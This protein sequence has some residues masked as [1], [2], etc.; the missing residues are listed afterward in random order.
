MKKEQT[1]MKWK[2][3]LKKVFYNINVRNYRLFLEEEEQEKMRK[4]RV[5]GPI[6][7]KKTKK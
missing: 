1:G 7:Q 5:K 4:N 3:K 2:K 6:P